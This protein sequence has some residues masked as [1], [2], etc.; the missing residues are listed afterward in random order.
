MN[1]GIC[2]PLTRLDV[3][4]EEWDYNWIFLFSTNHEVLVYKK[5]F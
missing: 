4:I 1:P 3:D 2:V 5:C